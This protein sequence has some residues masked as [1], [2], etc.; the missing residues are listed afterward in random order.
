LI[1]AIVLGLFHETH[2]R[3]IGVAIFLMTGTAVCIE[4]AGG[5]LTFGDPL[6]QLDHIVMFG[7][8]SLAGAAMAWMCEY[9]EY[10]MALALNIEGLIFW[11]HAQMQNDEEMWLHESLSLLAWSTAIFMMKRAHVPAMC[12]LF[13]Q[14]LF[15]LVITHDVFYDRG[16]EH[17]HA[18]TKLGMVLIVTAACFGV[19]LLRRERRLK[20][21]PQEPATDD[22]RSGIV[23]TFSSS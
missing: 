1:T 17:A 11:G 2:L 19:P 21:A 6:F 23:T 15:F 3:G 5:I 9:W 8:Y 20:A 10:F 12:G 14:G 22:E 7:S 4:M 16:H 18:F 13:A